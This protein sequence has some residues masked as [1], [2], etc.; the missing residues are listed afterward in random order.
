MRDVRTEVVRSLEIALRDNG[1]PNPEWMAR[2]AA[3]IVESHGIK[4]NRP[5]LADDPA[6]DFTKTV[7]AGNT[8]AGAPAVRAEIRRPAD[9][10]EVPQQ[11]APP[12]WR[13]AA[14]PD[15]GPEPTLICLDLRHNQCPGRQPS[16]PTCTCS[17]HRKPA[18]E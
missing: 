2:S 5:A 12:P 18:D 7:P 15:F 3:T 11:L 13:V 4:L 14:A 1:C 9:T 8:L 17:C 6:A 10:T 16:G